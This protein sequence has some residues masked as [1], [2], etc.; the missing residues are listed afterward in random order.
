MYLAGIGTLVERGA[1]WRLTYTLCGHWQELPRVGLEA[2]QAAEE[3]R[4][5]YARCLTCLTSRDR[6]DA[7]GGK[8]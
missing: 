2:E 6:T 3:V 5:D 8:H 7:P 1:V 4:F